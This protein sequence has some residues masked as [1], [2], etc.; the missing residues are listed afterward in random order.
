VSSL[1]PSASDGTWGGPKLIHGRIGSSVVPPIA[2]QVPVSSSWCEASGIAPTAARVL[3]VDWH[4]NDGLAISP[5]YKV[6][7]SSVTVT[8]VESTTT[9]TTLF[10]VAIV[11]ANVDNGCSFQS[12]PFA[13][14]PS[15]LI[16]AT[17]KCSSCL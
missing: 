2:K 5:R 11:N 10:V 4:L 9:V 15:R 8:Y 6:P 3:G 14:G 12:L 1:T 17:P 16:A 7:S 13:V